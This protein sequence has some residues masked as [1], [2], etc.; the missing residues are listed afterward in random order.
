MTNVTVVAAGNGGAAIAAW[1]SLKGCKIK[2]YDKFESQLAEIKKTGGILLRGHY[3]SGFA[4]ITKATTN[5]E[6][7]LED[8]ELIMVVTPAFAHAEI[9]RL[10]APYLIH[11]QIVVLNPGRTGG[12]I[13]FNKTV[14]EINPEASFTV[15]EAQSLIFACRITGPAEVTIYEMKRKMAVAA[16]PASET[17]RVVSKLNPYFPQFT[18]AKNVLETS[19]ANIGAIFHPAPTIL[20]IARI[21]AKKAFEYYR[22]GIS[23]CVAEVLE[24]LDKER[25]ELAKRIGINIPDAKS[26]L[27][28]V[29]G[30]PIAPSESLYEAIQKQKAYRGILAPK[31]PFARYITEDVPMSL[32]PLSELSKA[33]DV[34]TPV[35]DSIICIANALHK[36]DYRSIGRNLKTLGLE[37]KTKEQIIDLVS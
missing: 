1:L 26:W 19:L 13:E 36:C 2:I 9:A 31:D 27:Q 7:A 33:F 11:D 15:A 5:I 37:G 34:K 16:M 6:E 14:K 25:L 17:Q 4:P 20:N 28:D 32:V 29:Y 23:P 10:C 21:E 22:E 12:A 8:S 3:L 24:E 35:M 30:I 18:A